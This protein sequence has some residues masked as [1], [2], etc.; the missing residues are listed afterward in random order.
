M[1]FYVTTLTI[2]SS[3][4]DDLVIFEMAT[5]YKDLKVSQTESGRSHI[6]RMVTEIT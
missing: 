6:H 2:R 3:E 5:P 1:N 4:S